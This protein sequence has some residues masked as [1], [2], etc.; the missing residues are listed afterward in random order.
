MK[1][2]N[3]DPVQDY[4]LEDENKLR[5]A[6]AVFN[7]WPEVRKK[8]VSPFLDRLERALRLK[9]ELKDGWEF[10][11]WRC[12]F[13]DRE[14]SFSFGKLAWNV[15][16]DV[17][18]SLLD[19]GE[20]VKF[21]LGRNADLEHVKNRPH[22]DELLTAVREHY[23]SARPHGWWEAYVIM[24]PPAADW[25]KPEVLWRMRDENEEFLNEVVEQLLEMA[26]ITAPFVDQLVGKK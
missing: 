9:K 4:I 5:T 2:M 6:A 15:E 26:I 19:Y 3:S 20:D 7:A 8:L 24:P 17:S 18:L 10:E 1:T 14:A 16:Y 13:E 23:P 25:R 22:C 21:G 12:P 11:R